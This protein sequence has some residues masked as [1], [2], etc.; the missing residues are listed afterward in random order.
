MSSKTKV[1]GYHNDEEDH[2]DF[3]KSWKIVF[4]RP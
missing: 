4:S 2:Y 3:E 1:I